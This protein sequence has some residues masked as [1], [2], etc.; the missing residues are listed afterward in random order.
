MKVQMPTQGW[1]ASSF[2]ARARYR[3]L[4][5]SAFCMACAVSLRAQPAAPAE[6]KA[7]PEPAAVAEARGLALRHQKGAKTRVQALIRAE[8][9]AAVRAR[10]V[11]IQA[12]LPAKEQSAADY[13]AALTDADPGVRL[14]AVNAVGKL[15]GRE[16]GTR[17]VA[18]LA[19]A[20]PG[21][22]LAAAF[23]L[24]QPGHSGA[25]AAL[26]RVL[27]SDPDANVRLAA[28]QGL[29]RMGTRAARRL[30]RGAASDRDERVRRW[31]K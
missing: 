12:A 28:A 30:L 3:T 18:A 4:I 5:V 26:S 10:L 15:P 8:G 16:A 19:D 13:D 31:A 17:L 9:D 6:G 27:A 23:W 20:K 2:H 25:A 21:V 14:A 7:A 29:S 11:S 24:G 22:R 1:T